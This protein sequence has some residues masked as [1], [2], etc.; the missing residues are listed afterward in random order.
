MRSGTSALLELL[1]GT[2]WILSVQVVAICVLYCV[3]QA[4]TLRMTWRDWIFALPVGMALAITLGVEKTGDTI[5]YYFVWLWRFLTGGRGELNMEMV[6]LGGLFAAAGMLGLIY[7]LTR[8]WF[9]ARILLASTTIVA[10]YLAGSLLLRA[11]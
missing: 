4:R 3:Y 8:E 9:G 5:R 11:F 10:V 6:A 7:V 1:N 2:L